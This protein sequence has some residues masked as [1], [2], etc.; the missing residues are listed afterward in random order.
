M[1]KNYFCK[2]KKKLKKTKPQPAICHFFSLVEIIYV[3]FQLSL[4]KNHTKK[5][6][7]VTKKLIFQKK[8]VI[9]HNFYNY[10]L[11]QSLL[12]LFVNVR[13]G[14]NNFNI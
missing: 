6:F 3:L 12:M 4:L 5:L 2:D 14:C 8:I 9:L 13:V 10:L 11:T 1:I 7:F